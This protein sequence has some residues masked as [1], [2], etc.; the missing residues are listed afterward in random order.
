MLTCRST[1]GAIVALSLLTFVA[2]GH[3]AAPTDGD[4][5]SC[6][7]YRRIHSSILNEDRVLL[8]R[9]PV[10]Y[11]TAN[12]R[13]PVLYKLDGSRDVFLETVGTVEYLADRVDGFP[14][15]IIVAIENTDRN[16]DMLPGR[17]AGDFNRF[18][19]EELTQ[20]IDANYRTNGFRVLCGQ[21]L[22]SVFAVYSFLKKPTSFDGYVLSS[23]GLS[24]EWLSLFEKELGKS[25]AAAKRRQYLYVANGKLDSYDP[26]GTRTKNGLIFL[27]S[28]RK[29]SAATLLVKYQVY[30]G[31]GHV[32]FPTIY[33]AL[34]WVQASAIAQRQ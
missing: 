26:D 3:A 7:I 33:D 32:P 4:A 8:I 24:P 5:V 31:E 6:G 27:D 17:G 20:F 18:L 30:D 2:V 14:D 28:L 19:T 10:D 1:A 23:F 29:S 15:H 34:K 9:L 25:P 21:S 22:S 12:K 13:S 11:G 16:R